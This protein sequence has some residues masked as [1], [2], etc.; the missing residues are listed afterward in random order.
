MMGHRR[1][2]AAPALTP[3][4]AAGATDLAVV[5]A[6]VTGEAAAAGDS[7]AATEEEAAGVPEEV[8]AAG[9]EAV[10]AVDSEETEAVVLG[11]GV[12]GLEAGPFERRVY[13]RNF[14]LMCV[15]YLFQAFFAP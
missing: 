8:S 11:A 12:V 15:P 6:E 2:S 4:L 13:V 7:M 10:A 9:L 14:V 5:S 3:C 1:P